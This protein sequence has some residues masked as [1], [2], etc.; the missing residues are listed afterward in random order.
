M[1]G[2]AGMLGFVLRQVDWS[3]DFVSGSWCRIELTKNVVFLY[4]RSL[5]RKVCGSIL[6]FEVL[7]V[8]QSIF[9]SMPLPKAALCSLVSRRISRLMQGVLSAF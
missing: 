4:A 6:R 9:A 5:S 7:S 8:L 1:C 2:W 3:G